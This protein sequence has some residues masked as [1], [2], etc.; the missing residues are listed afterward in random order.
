MSDF[1]PP[2]NFLLYI[3]SFSSDLKLLFPKIAENLMAS[4]KVY[5]ISVL[6]VLSN[7]FTSLPSNSD[8]HYDVFNCIF[9]IAVS[10]G[11]YDAIVSQLKFLPKWFSDWS[12]NSEK[13]HALYLKV[14]KAFEDIDMK[15]DFY[16]IEILR[17][18]IV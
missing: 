8:L 15:Y 6:S 4:S 10:S 9:D 16:Q 11:N 17:R 12:V 5:P 2:Y 14:S 7:F 1:E 13:Q 18:I 3:V